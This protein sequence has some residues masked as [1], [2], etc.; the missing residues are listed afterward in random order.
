[1]VGGYFPLL[2]SKVRQFF[3]I[4]LIMGFS[5][6][7]YGQRDDDTI[8]SDTAQISEM[9]SS[10]INFDTTNTNMVVQPKEFIGLTIKPSN[11]GVILRWAPTTQELFD[12]GLELGYVI[13][14]YEYP[15]GEDTLTIDEDSFIETWVAGANNPVLPYDSAQWASLLPIENKYAIIAAAATTGS[16]AASSDMGFGVKAKQD[17][18]MF[19]YTLLSA[20]LSTLAAD[21]LG[22]RLVD[23]NVRVGKDYEYRVI[24]NDPREIAK[25]DSIY[26]L[27]P[28][29]LDSA[30]IKQWGEWMDEQQY[31]IIQYQ[32]IAP[33]P[34]SIQGLFSVSG[35]KT[36]ELMW[37]VHENPGFSAYVIERSADGGRTY[38]SLTQNVFV[39][40]SINYVD[41]VQQSE[42]EVYFFTDELDTNYVEYTYRITAY[43]AF[44]DRSRPAFVKGMGRDLTPPKNPQLVSAA[45]LENEKRI[46]ISW[47]LPEVPEDFADLHIEYT[48][49]TDSTWLRLE[50]QSLDPNDTVYYHNP[51]P[52]EYAHYFRMA[53]RDTA[54]NT[55]YSFPIFVNIPDTIPPLPPINL[56]AKIDTTGQVD[57]TWEDELPDK[58]GFL[59]YRV[60][61]SN[62]PNHEFTQLTVKP[63][64]SNF[65]IYR[66]PVKTLTEKIYYK[67]QAVDKHYNHSEFSEVIEGRKPDVVP[68]VAPVMNTPRGTESHIALSW[69]KSP[70]EDVVKQIVTRTSNEVDNEPV[71][72]ELDGSLDTFL[73]ETAVP[74][75]IYSYSI[76]AVD[77][78]GLSSAAS[79]PMRGKVVD[80]KRLEKVSNLQVSFDEEQQELTLTWESNVTGDNAHFSIYRNIGSE[81]VKRYT[82]VEGVS[83]T[84]TEK[85]RKGGTYFY[86]IKVWDDENRKSLLSE[87]V[88]IQIGG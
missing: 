61:V 41:S 37:P 35:E 42:Q 33:Q 24:L 62:H 75:A 45:Y 79:M 48:E 26:A 46:R 17:N 68:P 72:F 58:E 57:I 80:R 30:Q 74:G 28:F 44:A 8:P 87:W 51:L 70:S 23:R 88:S 47:R 54:N 86:A 53:L 22:F 32:G 63:V 29:E 31:N 43:D 73:D 3:L 81:K 60:F 64:P 77:D 12:R 13:K 83:T 34:R 52:D 6:S 59:G 2:C 66:I 19:G 39:S 82:T 67:V 14:R 76:K 11:E 27:D 5:L 18:S 49:H 16:L 7:T 84:F 20:D 50:S 71:S 56:A 36:I 1:M 69:R 9:L 10:F 38:D 78:Y 15:S 55:A 65:Y 4:G 25:A 85:I 21:G 40:T